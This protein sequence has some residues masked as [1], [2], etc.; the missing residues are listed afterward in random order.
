MRK[1]NVDG[2]N[3]KNAPTMGQRIAAAR[4]RR[5]LTQSDLAD[6]L[7][8]TPQAVSKWE[9]DGSLPDISMLAPLAKVLELTLDQLLTGA[10][11]PEVAEAQAA[12][13]ETPPEAAPR[14]FWGR[15]LGEV[16]EDIHGDVGTIVGEVRADIYGDV[17]GNI[18]GEVRNI[19][20]NVEG[21]V[22]GEVHGDVTGYIG[23]HLLGTVHGRVGLGIRGKILGTVVG[24]GINVDPEPRSKRSAERG[25]AR[26]RRAAAQ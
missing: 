15:I 18:V 10:G 19:Y 17:K 2:M 21:K 20:G 11:Y 13:G 24:D 1:R 3:D 8:V 7:N 22:V 25:S 5:G 26:G 9:T 6:A 23:G 12:P 14:A 4:K 16:T